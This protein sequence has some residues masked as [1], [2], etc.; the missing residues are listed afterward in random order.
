MVSPRTGLE[1]L[2]RHCGRSFRRYLSPQSGTREEIMSRL[3][4]RLSTWTIA[5][6]MFFV[7]SGISVLAKPQASSTDDQT[8]TTTKKKKKKAKKDASAAGDHSAADT[9]SAAT[10]KS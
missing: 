4:T 1:A 3:Q 2:R 7:L 8:S 6:C 5:L 10:K 9:S